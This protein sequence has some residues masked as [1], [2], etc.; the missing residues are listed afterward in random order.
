MLHV[1]TACSFLPQEL[2]DQYV[3]RIPATAGNLCST[4]KNYGAAF[5]DVMDT[6]L[7]TSSSMIVTK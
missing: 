1:M 7:A 3:A 2:N 4:R 5:F 6:I